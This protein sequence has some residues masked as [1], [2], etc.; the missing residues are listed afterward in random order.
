LDVRGVLACGTGTMGRHVINSTAKGMGLPV[1]SWQHGFIGYNKRIT[2]FQH[3][4]E[5]MST[6]HSLVYGEETREDLLRGNEE[7][8]G[9]EVVAAGSF[10]LGAIRERA[11]AGPA[12][13]S[14]H[15]GGR[16]ASVLYITASY[17]TN[18]WFN[19]FSPALNDRRMLGAQLEIIRSLDRLVAEG[20]ISAIVKL[21]PLFQSLAAEDI[22]DYNVEVV[23][24]ERSLEDMVLECDAI[25]IDVPTTTLLMSVSTGKPV[26]TLM[27]L[28]RYSDDEIRKL[29]RRAVCASST[30]ELLKEIEAYVRHGDYPADVCDDT[31]WNS[32][33]SPGPPGAS[34]IQYTRGRALEVLERML[35]P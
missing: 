12:S 23:R 4:I 2:Q 17:Y 16:P 18:H 5:M 31:F 8:F 35:A 21:N 19:G 14:W 29:S 28:V 22:R 27:S 26:F 11:L 13:K 20:K 33:C 6:T 7:G 34:G 1:I 30:A 24:S 25:V 10:I 32:Y 15:P 9:A 3:Y